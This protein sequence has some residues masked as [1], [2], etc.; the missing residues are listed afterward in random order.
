MHGRCNEYVLFHPSLDC[1]STHLL[2]L[3]WEITFNLKYLY[4]KKFP[5]VFFSLMFFSLAT[6]VHFINY[7]FIYNKASTKLRNPSVH[8]YVVTYIFLSGQW[9][10]MTIQQHISE[11]L[12]TWIKVTPSL[13]SKFNFFNSIQFKFSCCALLYSIEIIVYIYSNYTFSK[14][15]KY[16]TNSVTV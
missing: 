13:V 1:F 16:F 2:I 5:Y 11:A 8:G 9:T 4:M 7:G 14:T 6:S 12:S 3:L 15:N 10:I